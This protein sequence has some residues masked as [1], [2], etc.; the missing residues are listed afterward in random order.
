MNQDRK[1]FNRLVDALDTLV[2]QESATLAERDYA[3]AIAIQQRAQPVV[4]C[5][6]ALG[7]EMA[8][9][10]A[11]ARIAGL[12]ARRQHSIDLLESQLAI[13]RDELLALQE[14][15]SRVARVAPVYGRPRNAPPAERRF[16]AQG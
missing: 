7:S 2:A 14:G 6:L 4:D 5:L 1:K 10:I 8:D 16:S 13:A 11:R 3:A 9:E 15:A 12:L